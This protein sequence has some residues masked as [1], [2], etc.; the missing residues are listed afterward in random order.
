MN[1][2]AAGEPHQS[3]PP[4][5][6]KLS[7]NHTVGV[8]DGGSSPTKEV[9]PGPYGSS[10]NKPKQALPWMAELKQK[11]DRKSIVNVNTSSNNVSSVTVSTSNVSQKESSP[12]P[13]P[14][15]ITTRAPPLPAKP[16]IPSIPSPTVTDKPI[17]N[18]SSS[19]HPN[20]NIVNSTTTVSS[21]SAITTSASS[22]TSTASSKFGYMKRMGVS[23][24]AIGP[25]ASTGSNHH[26]NSNATE[27]PDFVSYEEYSKLK[28][29]VSHLES[30]LELVKKQ[31]KLLLDRDFTKGHIV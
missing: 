25:N 11:Q 26:N 23:T 10:V 12:S 28:D 27:T 14:P 17:V 18:N 19:H 24:P 20:N 6:H 1:E 16:Q 15:P 7:S 4:A 3:H 22:V 31:V 13:T 8:G 2:P 30:E 29:K 21:S 9:S 5:N